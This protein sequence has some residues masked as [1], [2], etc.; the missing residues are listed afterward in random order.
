MEHA[1]AALRSIAIIGGGSAGW[2]A[3]AAL[4]NLLGE[5]VKITLVESDEI[6]TVGVGEATIPHIKSFNHMLGV[7]ENEFVQ[8]TQASF[9]LGI[10]FVNWRQ[11]GH[12]YFHPFGS[13]GADFDIASLYHY[14]L[15]AHLNG[16]ATPLDDYSMCW[17]L[18]RENRFGPPNPNPRLVHSTHAYAYHFD[19]GLYAQF[20]RHY[21]ETRGVA[22]QE[23]KI[24]QVVQ[25]ALTGFITH[26]ELEDGRN[27]AADFFI[28]CTGFAA[29]LI[30]KT[31]G[32]GFEDW[33]HWLPCNRALAVPSE[34]CVPL[35]PYTRSTAHE[36]GW[37]WRIPLQHRQGNGYVF[38][39]D[40]M[41]EEEAQE[42]LLRTA[43]SKALATPRL[44][45]F[46]TSRRTQAWRA[47]CVSLGLASGFIEPLESTS[48]H[49]IQTGIEKLLRLLP[50]C[51]MN[52]LLAEEYNRASATEMERIRDFI[53]LHYHANERPEPFWRYCANMSIPDELAY[54]M[55]H[56][57][58]SARL[59]S[60]HDELFLN[61]S[62]LAVYIGQGII[63]QTYDSL[64]DRQPVEEVTAHM[65]K[66][67]DM[68]REAAG[69]FPTH[70]AYIA[71]HCAAP[72]RG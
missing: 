18:A 3:A 27:V 24:V 51:H 4:S 56:F 41:G 14:W 46:T 65:R 20:L 68:M 17:A 8:A 33:S 11:H 62:W 47:N 49:L 29:L 37:Q 55:K 64:C 22:R 5:R 31:L 38:C 40:Y 57:K 66:L 54:K 12:S 42:R 39:A 67:R 44:I 53:I 58:G 52:P 59:V 45:K 43:G 19:A 10:E 32:S 13:Y 21:A 23:G 26:V 63:P 36:A 1:E 48:L 25:D 71:R 50:D 28:D 72:A 61:P 34:N 60:P 16:D 70:E 30:G 6:G 69:T 35:T 7:T 15:R 2:M 9:K